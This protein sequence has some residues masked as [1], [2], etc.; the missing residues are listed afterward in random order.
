MSERIQRERR[1][2]ASVHVHENIAVD[3]LCRVFRQKRVELS[4]Q[5]SRHVCLT[6]LGVVERVQHNLRKRTASRLV[7]VGWLVNAGC[8][9]K[10]LARTWW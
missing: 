3:W 9:Y 6:F 4:L 7:N 2:A 8:S 1:A 5:E 10:T